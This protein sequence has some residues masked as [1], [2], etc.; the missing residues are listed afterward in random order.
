MR[1][2]AGQVQHQLHGGSYRG[3]AREP[4]PVVLRARGV[5]PAGLRALSYESAR[6]EAAGLR[7]SHPRSS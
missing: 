1:L 3:S 4:A 6:L 2:P 5:S 7:G